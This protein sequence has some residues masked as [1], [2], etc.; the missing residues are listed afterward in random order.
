M[1]AV[2]LGGAPGVLLGIFVVL[3]AAI[4]L[5]R[6]GVRTRRWRYRH[7]R[8]DGGTPFPAEASI[9]RVRLLAALGQ[10]VVAIVLGSAV[11]ALLAAY[12]P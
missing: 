12:F 7:R 9:E 1:L 2:S 5:A 8:L 3:T 6:F 4:R 10:G 11:L